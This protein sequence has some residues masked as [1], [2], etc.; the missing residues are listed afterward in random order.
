MILLGGFAQSTSVTEVT[1]ADG[2][3]GNSVNTTV[4]RKNSL[5]TFRDTQVIAFYNQEHYVV[6]GKRH[7]N[8]TQWQLQQTPFRGNVNDAHN[9]ISIMADGKGYLHMAWD[10][11]NNQLHYSR[12]IRP[13]SLELTAAMPM[14]GL[15]EQRVTYPEFYKMPNG[16]LLFF[17]RN[18][19]SGN[20]NLVINQY[21]VQTGQW[22]QLQSNLIDG[23]NQR[24]AYWQACMDN[25]G[26]IHIS[27]VW[28]ECRRGQQ[29]RFVL[30]PLCRWRQNMG[31][32]YR[33]AIPVTHHSGYSRICLYHTAKKRIN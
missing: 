14:T 30:C 7:V 23:Q 22:T 4:F 13:F 19:Q 3:A 6:L 33:G 28:R 21:A 2:W 10:H 11:H 32:I 16:N 5:V 18:G 26:I 31:K 24:S 15:L 12:S 17:Y 27:W 9:V 1:V 25:K 29:P 8:T 20:G